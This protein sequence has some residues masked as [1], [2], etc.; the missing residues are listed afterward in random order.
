MHLAGKEFELLVGAPA[1]EL[2]RVFTKDELLRDVWGYR[3]FTPTRV[4]FRFA[5]FAAA[6]EAR[7]G[8]RTTASSSTRWG[9]A[10]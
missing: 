4:Y 6:P 1:D 10:S 7:A 3:S 9:V 2:H 8:S 5:R